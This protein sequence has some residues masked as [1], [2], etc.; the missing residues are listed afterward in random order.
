MHSTCLAQAQLCHPK[1][2][3][4]DLT[5]NPALDTLAL[6]SPLGPLNGDNAYSPQIPD[7]KL[8]VTSKVQFLQLQHVF[9]QNATNTVPSHVRRHT[10]L[11]QPS[12]HLITQ[13][14][15]NTHN[16]S[17]VLQHQKQTQYSMLQIKTLSLNTF[18]LSPSYFF[19]ILLLLFLTNLAR[20]LQHSARKQHN[21]NTHTLQP[22]H[23]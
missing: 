16:L 13:F 9:R 8:T 4:V 6:N 23:R 21:V 2:G 18:R 12:Q 10:L 19:I 22:I 20:A 15:L 5:R 11:S 17:R 1:I 3:Y 14:R 7:T